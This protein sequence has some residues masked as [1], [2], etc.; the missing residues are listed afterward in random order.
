MDEVKK[1]WHSKTLWAN[2][3]YVVAVVSVQFFGYEITPETQLSV[4][5]IINIILRF[6]TTEPIKE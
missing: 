1:W 3:L 2:F 6:Y 5:G 4:L